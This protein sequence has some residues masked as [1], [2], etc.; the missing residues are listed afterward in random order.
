MGD[1]ADM[2]MIQGYEMW[3]DGELDESPRS[4]LI[5][6]YCG[7]KYFWWGIH[8]EKWRLFNDEGVHLCITRKNK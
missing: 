1:M 6:K 4:D 2:L 5:C 3:L 7:A 8:N